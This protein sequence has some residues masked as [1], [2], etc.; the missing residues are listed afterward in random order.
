MEDL[1][2]AARGIVADWVERLRVPSAGVVVLAA[3]RPEPLVEAYAGE[4]DADSLVPFASGG[5]P[6]TAAVAH[7]LAAGGAL[8]LDAPVAELWPAFARA[9]AGGDHDEPAGRDRVT[10]RDLLAHCSGLPET[11]PGTPGAAGRAEL[12]ADAAALALVDAPRT[13]RRYSNPGYALVG[14]LCE[15]AGF[16]LAW[17][18][19]ARELV[20]GPL[21]MADTAF[22]PDHAD[23][24]R[25]PRVRA[26]GSVAPGVQMFNSDYYRTAALPQGGAYGT[27]ADLA[28]LAAAFLPGAG[29]PL[30]A[31]ARAAMTTT[32]QRGLPGGIPSVWEW[33]DAAW[34]QGFDLHDTK[35]PY[36]GG[37][38][39][40]PAT[41]AHT[42][43]SGTMTVG[44]P[45]RGVAFALVGLRGVGAGWTMPDALPDAADR[46]WAALEA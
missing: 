16:G 30:G 5:K 44:D 2:D 17:P 41:F 32:W 43:W 4:M 1:A 45:E 18:A 15:A 11:G 37:S 6:I 13:R 33:D 26:P 12:A 14:A 29:D 36:W 20:L 10:T 22:A 40:S 34:G 28:R 8:D 3:G 42:G 21:G 39:S 46:L 31:A 9:G 7:V 38:R 27:V 25:I 23:W 24:P 35:A 19:L